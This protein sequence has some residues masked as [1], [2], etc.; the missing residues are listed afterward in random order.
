MVKTFK[1]SDSSLAALC[2]WDVRVS[3][4]VADYASILYTKFYR[5]WSKFVETTKKK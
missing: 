3:S 2:V 5:N 1:F 4:C